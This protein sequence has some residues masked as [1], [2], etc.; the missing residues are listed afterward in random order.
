M[1][2]AK[3]EGGVPRL[4]HDVATLRRSRFMTCILLAI[5]PALIVLFAMSDRQTPALALDMGIISIVIIAFSWWNI[6]LLNRHLR[7]PTYFEVRDGLA[8]HHDLM[9]CRTYRLAGADPVIGKR[10]ISLRYEE[11]GR[12]RSKR[13]L[14]PSSVRKWMRRTRCDP[15][16]VPRSR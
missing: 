2:V 16:S 4:E 14:L 1:Q 8:V 11:G 12:V 9:R 13:I 3:Q 10:A 15:R 6:A 7:D 5:V